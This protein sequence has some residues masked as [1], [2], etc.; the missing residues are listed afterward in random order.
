[1]NTVLTIALNEG[2]AL[3]RNRTAVISAALYLL[4][5]I[6]A[7]FNA[8]DQFRHTEG[9]RASYQSEANETF[10]AQPDRHPHRMVHY[11]HFVFRPLNPM[12]AFDPGVDAFTGHMLYLEGH[13][14]NSANF[15]DT[16]QNTSLVRFGQLTPAFCLQILAPLLLVFLG[17]GAVTRERERGTLSLCL[18]Q[19]IGGPQLFWGKTLCL[20]AVAGIILLPAAATLCWLAVS[21]G[22]G[23]D[24]TT[25]MVFGY[26]LYLLLWT[27]AAVLVSTLV[28]RGRDALLMLVAAWACLC[29]FIPRIAPDLVARARPL[30]TQMETDIRIHKDLKAMGD[31]H[32]PDDPYFN[33]FKQKVLDSYGVTRI[34]DLPVNYKGLLAIEGERMTSDLFKAYGHRNF[35]QQKAQSRMQDALGW[36]APVIALQRLS[37]SGSGTDLAAYHAFLDQGEAYRFG[38]VQHL[39]RLQ[40]TALTYADDTNKTRENRITHSHWTRYPDFT[41]RPPD[42][43]A[44]RDAVF[45]ALGILLI[46]V[47]ALLALGQWSA[48][49]LERTA[50]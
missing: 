16:R 24:L 9:L 38:L 44:R 32:N 33:A 28:A 37:M 46:W 29:V 15:S 14:Q 34:E 21:A 6:M 41:F 7:M 36:L 42:S 19:G 45:P 39:N 43:N 35:A 13:R 2:R 49:R 31:S 25:A 40:A 50:I 4:L 3:S 5:S 26:T 12:A 47:V 18:S 17:Y 22:L 11:G 10:D 8:W 48:L 23:A 20:A 27:V 1:M 30:L